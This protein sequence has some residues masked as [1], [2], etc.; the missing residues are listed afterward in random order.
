MSA[1]MLDML[2]GYIDRFDDDYDDLMMTLILTIRLRPIL[3]IFMI[4]LVLMI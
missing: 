2:I 4:S 1:K 3:T